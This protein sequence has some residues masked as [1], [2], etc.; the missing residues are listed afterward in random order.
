MSI[1]MA[2]PILQSMALLVSGIAKLGD[3]RGT[4]DAMVSLRLPLRRVHPLIASVLPGLEIVL[5]L[6]V[7]VPLVP[8]QV[9]LGEIALLLMLAYLVIIARALT[10]E[11]K[12]SCSCF[13]SLS[14]PT[15]S[16]ATLARNVLLSALAALTLVAAATGTMSET[17][18]R[19]PLLLLV[20]VLVLAGTILLTVLVV[21]GTQSEDD[22]EEAAAVARSRSTGPTAP[23]APA[24]P[25]GA[26]AVGP[27]PAGPSADGGHA[28][29][30][31]TV[32]DADDE[33]L[34][35]ERTPIPAAV[36]QRADGSL[37]TLRR[38]TAD[39][40]ALLVFV[41]E[42]CGPCER[43]L[44]RMPGWISE[45]GPFLQVIAVVKR[46]IGQLFP[47]TLERVGEQVLHDPDFI[48]R[49]ALDA[50][51]T[52]SAV[53]LGADGLLAGGPVRGGDEVIQFVEEILEQI[54]E[55]QA[56]GELASP[57]I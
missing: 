2:A 32:L 13:G 14:A 23:A 28:A 34:D 9:V 24:D 20:Q 35:Y 11:E 36:L 29:G 53:L 12:V 56:D 40:A 6:M 49:T 8:L 41:S 4:Q 7:W 31:G 55:A 54:R 22:E 19:T 46:P 1:L 37:V 15:V 18:V 27:D 17:L 47:G 42:G 30:P 44:D 51:G 16:K 33:L 45:L 50:N 3:R 5:A 52:P 25:S 26:S 21:A 38:L 43:A 57:S 10:F 39:R 48:A